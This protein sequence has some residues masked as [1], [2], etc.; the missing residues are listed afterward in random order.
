MPR[1]FDTVILAGV[2]ALCLAQTGCG[3]SPSGESG[4]GSAV[5]ALTG[6]L[7][8]DEAAKAKLNAY[9]DAHNELLGTFGL[10]ETAKN[11]LENDIA[12]KAAVDSIFVTNGSLDNSLAKLKQA[13]ALPGGSSRLNA[14][15]DRLIADLGKA[16]AHIDALRIYYEAKSYKEDGLARGK[17]EDPAMKAEF[18]TALASLQTFETVLDDERSSRDNAEMDAMKAHGDM[19][20]YDTRLALH[21]GKALVSLF[22][23]AADV[24]NPAVMAKADV[25][26]ATLEQTLT[27]QRAELAKR[28]ANPKTSADSANG[29]YGS[30]AESLT[31]L[32]GE[33]RDLKQTRD[34]NHVEQMIS[35]YNSAIS[36]SNSLRYFTH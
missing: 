9:T 1:S 32:I 21:Q 8:G 29:E 23:S 4:A 36:S 18:Q 22:K 2:L 10:A 3:K 12:R 25:L 24:T 33:Y 15:A 19:L 11:Y 35:Q 34:T 27:A 28:T 26:S 16:T 7:S 6:A 31:S 14:A 5:S 20:A 13:R 17:R 30:V